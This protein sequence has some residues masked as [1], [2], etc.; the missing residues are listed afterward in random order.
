MARSTALRFVCKW[1]LA[2]AAAVLLG[3]PAAVTGT[4]PAPAA[5]AGKTT[6]PAR[7]SV[8]VHRDLGGGRTRA[9]TGT[10]V[11]CEGGKSLVLTNAHVA[12]DPDGAYVVTHAG[13]AYPATYVAGSAVTAV[14]ATTSRIDGPDLA[15]VAVDATLPAAA[16]A[17]DAPRPGDRVRLWGFG[18]RLAEQGA[19]EK[20][21]EAL[22]AAGYVDPTFVSTTET[23]SGDSGSGVFNDTGELVAVHWGGGDG[24]A[25]AVP[26]GTVRG[27]LREKA[28]G[29]FPQLAGRMGAEP[30]RTPNAAPEKAEPAMPPPSR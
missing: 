13:T 11:G 8:Y 17:P 24:R 20:A 9:G 14:T 6:D 2:L 4:E 1:L 19:A 21:G 27:F 30:K 28:R 12:D 18:G 23:S 7:S 10:V 22:D 5:G 25:F 29:S 15:L 3:P 26:L 16:F